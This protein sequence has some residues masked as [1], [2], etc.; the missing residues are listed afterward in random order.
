MAC[1]KEIEYDLTASK[2]LA[3]FNG[4]EFDVAVTMECGDQ[5]PLI[6]AKQRLDWSIPDPR[7]MPPQ[8]FR[9]VRDL[10]EAR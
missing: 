10:I 2:G 3:H 8:S 7:E 1:G 4:E 9:K 5:C 6:L